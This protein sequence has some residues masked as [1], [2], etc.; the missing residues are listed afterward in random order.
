VPKVSREHLEARREQILDGAR[1]AFSDHGY[2]GATVAR[3]EAATGLSRGAIFH[4][5]GS[6][7]DLFVEL[8]WDLNRRLGDILL[9]RGLD[10]TVRAIARESPEWL[11]VLI[12]AQ[13]K[14]R[15]DPEFVKKMEARE[16]ES[17]RMLDWFEQ[18]QAEGALR[19]DIPSVE[20]GRYA[21]AVINGL[22]LRIVG[23]DPFDIEAA[24][25]LL[26]DSLAPR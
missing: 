2:E 15:H 6:K 8:A 4:Y 19:A 17:S 18:R 10:D 3:L 14:L 5:F 24:I 22:A 11:G 26:N 1:R 13:A 7:Q 23:D 25:R 21:T 16:A 9:E 12:E 20:L